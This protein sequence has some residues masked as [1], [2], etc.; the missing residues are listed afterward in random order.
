M[1]IIIN[2]HSVFCHICTVIFITTLHYQSKEYR[3]GK[4]FKGFKCSIKATGKNA[5]R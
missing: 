3:T 1:L 4:W 5:C 2:A